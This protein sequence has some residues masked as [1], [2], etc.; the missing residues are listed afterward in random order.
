MHDSP[1]TRVRAEILQ[2]N[3]HMARMLVV[4][5]DNQ[6]RALLRLVGERCGYHVDDA[7]DGVDAM[8]LL[9][10]HDYSMA[11]IDLM[12]P[13]LSGY[14]VLDRLRDAQKRPKFI[15]VTAM[16]DEYVARITNDLA[17]AIVRKPFDLTMLTA[18]IRAVSSTIEGV[19]SEAE[20]QRQRDRQRI[21]I[22]RDGL[23]AG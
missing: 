17:D 7:R 8:E 1:P 18:V 16:T 4:D 15:V 14:D 11:L 13:R 21:E 10:T 19:A 3:P 12:M 22:K 6:I 20:L 2:D 5:D 9:Q 23:S